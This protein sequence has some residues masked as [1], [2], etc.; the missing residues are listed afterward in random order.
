MEMGAYLQVAAGDGDTILPTDDV[1]V[2][3]V[4]LTAGSFAE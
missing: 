1:R 2:A 4:Q 3:R